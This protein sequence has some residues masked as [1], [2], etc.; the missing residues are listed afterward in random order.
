MNRVQD[1]AGFTVRL[2]GIGYV[3]LWP[4][5]AMPQSGAPLGAAHVCAVPPLQY[6]C[7]MPHP[8]A[9]PPVFH[10][11]GC[12]AAGWLAVRFSL[13]ALGRW[14]RARAARA[15]AARALTARIP[16]VALRLPRLKPAVPPRT[17]KARTHFGLRGP[18]P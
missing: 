16:A 2:L 3:V 8:L 1:Y 11:I 13:R 6:L 9:L 18:Q 10:V 7:D 15:C 12:A 5:T 4:F 17:V 14:R